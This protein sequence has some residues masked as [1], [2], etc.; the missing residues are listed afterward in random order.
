MVLAGDD[1]GL[2]RAATEHRLGLDAAKC[3][4]LG[5]TAVSVAWPRPEGVTALVERL[6]VAVWAAGEPAAAELTPGHLRHVG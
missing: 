5:A 3:L 6:R 2:A 1:R 4:A